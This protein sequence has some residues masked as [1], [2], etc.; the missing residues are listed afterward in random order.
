[1]WFPFPARVWQRAE[2]GKD[3]SWDSLY[4]H[5]QGFG[6]HLVFLMTLLLLTEEDHQRL[7]S[8]PWICT[9]NIA[10]YYP[11]RNRGFF[12]SLVRHSFCESEGF[13]AGTPLI[14]QMRKVWPILPLVVIWENS[15]PSL[16]QN[17]DRKVKPDRETESLVNN[18]GWDSDSRW[19]PRNVSFLF[20]K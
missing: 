18:A 13:K 16:P 20:S 1:M 5:P 17:L 7:L 6:N 9:G 3:V 14:F 11:P 15:W 10:R 4:P 19:C 12:S 8:D 2:F